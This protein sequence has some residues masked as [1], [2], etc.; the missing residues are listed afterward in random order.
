MGVT[1]SL[2]YCGSLNPGH[3]LHGLL[4]GSSDTCQVRLHPDTHLC[5]LHGIFWTTLPDLA[6]VLLN[7]KITNGKQSTVKMLPGSVFLCAG[8][9]PGLLGW[10]YPEQFGLSSAACGLVLG[11]SIHPYTDEVLLL[12]RIVSV[13]SLNKP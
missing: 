11:D 4:N 6:S 12:H 13:T 3:N 2:A 9:V 7:G 5:Q 10:A 1:L 8:L